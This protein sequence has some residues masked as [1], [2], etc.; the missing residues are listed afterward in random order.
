MIHS[1]IA[2]PSSEDFNDAY[3]RLECQ[4]RGCRNV[5]NYEAITSGPRLKPAI[6]PP[7]DKS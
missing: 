1:K 3:H 5:Q 7:K 6:E 2:P 4:C